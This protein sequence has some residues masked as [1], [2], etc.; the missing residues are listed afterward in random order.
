MKWV[1]LALLLLNAWLW[2]SLSKP[3]EYE[4][5]H[6][7]IKGTLPRVESLKSPDLRDD[8]RSEATGPEEFFNMGESI[9]KRCVTVGWFDTL[10]AAEALV[11]RGI[12]IQ[13]RGHQ[14]QK[15]ERELP[16]LYWVIIPPQPKQVA[17]NQLRNLQT[18]GVDSYLVAR[19][20]NRNAISLG[21]FES[22]E[23]AISVLNEKNHQNLNAILV[24]FHRNQ[25]SYALS[26]ET[27]AE[28]AEKLAL[29]ANPDYSD[30]FDFIEINACEG[31]ATPSKNP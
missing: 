2:Y 20:E 3:S 1:A 10:A 15:K 13:S 11:H 30:N 17:L 28:L 25:L 29:A 4:L 9:A 27:R 8:N 6:S 24:N 26:F 7:V 21:L 23:A 12:S 19:G 22:R 31:V 18:E 5:P 14:V 16:P